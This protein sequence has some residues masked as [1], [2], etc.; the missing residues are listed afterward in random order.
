MQT[1]EVTWKISWDGMGWPLG[2]SQV[3]IRGVNGAEGQNKNKSA[4]NQAPASLRVKMNQDSSEFIALK[5]RSQKHTWYTAKNLES[6]TR[7]QWR[8]NVA[9][10]SGVLKMF[11]PKGLQIKMAAWASTGSPPP[12]TPY[13]KKCKIKYLKIISIYYWPQNKERHFLGARDKW[14]VGT[15]ALWPLGIPGPG[16]YLR[17]WSFNTLPG[18]GA[19]ATEALQ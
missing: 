2:K 8:S 15:E 4:P 1:Q 19:E 7:L 17:S 5:S 18:K 3:R 13:T 14:W 16:L 9:Q 10:V 6:E 11:L 12:L